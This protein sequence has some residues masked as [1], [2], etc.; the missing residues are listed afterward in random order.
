MS[1][2]ELVYFGDKRERIDEAGNT[3]KLEPYIPDPLLVE[4]V[5]VAIDLQRPL[6]LKGEPGCGKTKLAKAVADELG[7]DFYEWP[8]KSTSRAQDGLYTYDTIGRLR[9]AQLAAN[10]NLS[11]EERE[12]INKKFENPRKYVSFGPLG[13]AF[14]SEKRA[15][16]LIDEIDKADIDFPNDLLHELEEKRFTIQELPPL[17]KDNKPVAFD[18]GGNLVRAK[19]V[20]IIFV[21]SN[22]EKELPAAFLRRCLFYYIDFPKTRRLREI[23]SLHLALTAED[24]QFVKDAVAKFRELRKQMADSKSNKKVSTSE[25]IDW[26]RIMKKRTRQQNKPW[27]SLNEE[28]LFPSVLLKTLTDLDRY[29]PPRQTEEEM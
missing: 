9:D 8:V 25:L 17:V 23:V 6:L 18:N 20:P 13:E 5:N 15:V 2:G 12:R 27:P 28:L 16:L 10:P 14:R 29:G 22:Q 24:D 3:I 1:E 4:A 21:T 26:I 11:R 7:L 19:S